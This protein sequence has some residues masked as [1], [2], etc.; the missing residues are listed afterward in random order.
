MLDELGLAVLR[1]QADRQFP[2]ELGP[3]ADRCMR[4]VRKV[5]PEIRLPSQAQPD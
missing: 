1:I 2:A 3:L 5:W 4:E